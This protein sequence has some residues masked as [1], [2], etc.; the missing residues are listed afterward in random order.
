MILLRLKPPL[1]SSFL[2]V[3][4]SHLFSRLPFSTTATPYPLYYELVNYRPVQSHKDAR[5]SAQHQ[6]DHQKDPSVSSSSGEEDAKEAPVM[7]R[8][9]RRYYAKRDKRMYGSDEPTTRSKG[10]TES[11]EL[12]P[13]IVDFPRLHAR[14]EELYFHDAFAF[15]WEKDKH[16]RM[17]SY[18]YDTILLCDF[19]TNSR[20]TWMLTL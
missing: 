14:E 17:V 3:K 19:M 16:Y 6:P 2:P 10:S 1:S 13:E 4:P 15:P 7:D 12:K 8:S 18:G 11:V 9:K 20:C 5:S